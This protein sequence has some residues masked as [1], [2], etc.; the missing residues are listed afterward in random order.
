M[1]SALDLA[2]LAQAVAFD[3]NGI[4]VRLGGLWEDAPGPAV[5]VWLRHFG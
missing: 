5:L 3:T 4:E 2:S 1:E